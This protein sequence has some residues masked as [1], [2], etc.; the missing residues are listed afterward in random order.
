MDRPSPAPNS[1]AR[2]TARP[3]VNRLAG[4]VGEV[5]SFLEG[6]MID[7]L[8]ERVISLRAA[9][10]LLPSRRGGRPAHVAT[11]YRWTTR[12]CRGVVLESVQIGATRCTSREALDRFFQ[13]LTAGSRGVSLKSVRTHDAV[14]R[15]LNQEGF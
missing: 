5:F 14:S 4:P 12:G 13:S 2:V 7:P 3:L 8:T 1:Y 11:L 9:V 10:H 15:E 6:R